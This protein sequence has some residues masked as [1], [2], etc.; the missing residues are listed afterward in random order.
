MGERTGRRY[1]LEFG[2]ALLAYAIVLAVAISLVTTTSSDSVWRVPLAL[3]PMVPLVFA[4]FAFVRYMSRVDE[5]QRRIQLEALAFAFGGTALLTFGYGFLQSI[6]GYPQVNWF[7]VWPV[8]AVL[9]LA[10]KARADRKY[11]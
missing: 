5:L 8:M 10:G 7:V 4:L 1:L 11:K 3:L 2:G 9:W 6:A